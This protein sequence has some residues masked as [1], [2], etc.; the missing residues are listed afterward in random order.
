MIK[1]SHLDRSSSKWYFKGLLPNF[2]TILQISFLYP[3]IRYRKGR[4]S[5]LLEHELTTGIAL[6][7]AFS[8]ITEK[9][10]SKDLF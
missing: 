6:S 5:R 10:T 4:K 8:F 9:L 3:L 2:S 1:I 7:K